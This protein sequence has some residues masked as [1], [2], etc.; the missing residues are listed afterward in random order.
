MMTK[1]EQALRDVEEL[2]AKMP[3]KIWESIK[4]SITDRDREHTSVAVLACCVRVI[5]HPDADLATR[6]KAQDVHEQVLRWVWSHQCD[7]DWKGTL[8]REVQ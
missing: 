1:H 2:I 3:P 8:V 6:M 4:A 7:R 5:M